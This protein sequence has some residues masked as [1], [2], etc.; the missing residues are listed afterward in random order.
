MKEIIVKYDGGEKKFSELPIETQEKVISWIKD[1][2]VPRKTP[3]KDRS[4][5]GLKHLIQH[6]KD[7]GIYLTNNQ[8]KDAMLTC[9]Y[10]PSNPDYVN[11]YFGISL[12][13]PAFDY[14]KNKLGRSIK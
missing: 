10:I 3:M 1:N 2:F 9:G 6:D 11:W 5:Y 12:K 4:S 7:C 8:F 14:R 13:S